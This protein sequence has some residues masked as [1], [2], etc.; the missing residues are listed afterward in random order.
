[1]ETSGKPRL[2]SRQLPPNQLDAS[3]ARKAGVA[4]NS[5]AFF[6]LARQILAQLPSRLFDIGADLATPGGSKHES[7]VMRINNAHIAEAERW[8]DEVD[9]GN[10]PMK[11]FVLPGGTELA[12]RL[13]LARTICRRAERSMVRLQ[14]GEPITPAA[15]I[16]I[17]RVADLLFAMARRANADAAV[18]DVPW[19]AGVSGTANH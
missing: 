17:N 1:M 8:I 16:Y 15:L 19:V 11:S 9:A 18:P 14:Q 13:H 4:S 10:A 12:A 2:T 5:P 7:K 3:S 6:D